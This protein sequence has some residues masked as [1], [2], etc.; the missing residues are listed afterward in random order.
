VTSSNVSVTIVPVLGFFTNGAGW[1]A[2]GTSYAWLGANSLELTADSG[3][4]SN[5]A[6]YFSPVYVGAFQ[7]SFNYQCTGSGTLADGAT[8]CIQNDPRGAGAVGIDGGDLGY[9][10]ATNGISNSVAFEFNIYGANAVG[11]VGVSF[12]TNGA[13]GPTV[14]TTNVTPPLLFTNGDIISNFVTYDGT[15]L[16]VTMTDA[17]AGS[18]FSLS[19]NLDIVNVLGTNVAYIGFTA[20]DG[21][22]KSTQVF[23]DFTYVPLV[24]LTIQTS[25]GATVISW[26]AGVGGYV[27]EQA[28]SLAPANWAPVTNTVNVANQQNQITLPTTATTEFYQLML[29]L[30]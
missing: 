11:G 5:S 27:L 17:A 10:S 26:P 20:A 28:S 9:G 3:S 8:F 7:A 22:S 23:S 13:I 1:S 14:Q 30:Q 4:E 18:T 25:G 6:F 2:Q 19:T 15:T 24:G 16:T 29:P 12:D 21:G